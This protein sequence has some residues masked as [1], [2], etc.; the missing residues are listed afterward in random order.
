MI[1]ALTIDQV[2]A[3]DN[4]LFSEDDQL[5][6]FPIPEVGELGVILSDPN[7]ETSVVGYAFAHPELTWEDEV[8]LHTLLNDRVAMLEAIGRA[9]RNDRAGMRAAILTELRQDE[10]KVDRVVQRVADGQA[11][12]VEMRQD[13][14][15]EARVAALIATRKAEMDRLLG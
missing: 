8:V 1:I 3:L 10:R 6:D 11:A 12:R 4:D 13:I 7:D 9:P 14:L 2:D 15:K 5:R